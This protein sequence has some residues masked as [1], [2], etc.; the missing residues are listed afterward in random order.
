MGERTSYP[1]GTFCWVDL[2]TDD[3]QAAKAFYGE[4]LGWQYEDTPIGEGQVYSMAR[5]D[6]HDVAAVGPLQGPEGVPPHWNCYVSVEDADATAARAAG[7]GAT[8]LAEPFDVFESGRMA[9]VQDPQGAIVSLWQPNNH[10]GATLVNAI[11]ALTWNDLISPDVDASASFYRGLFGWQI[12]EV[13]ESG[14][15]YWSIL[16]AGN[17]NGG[18]MPQPPD[19]HPAWN[20]YFAVEDVDATLARAAE[21]GGQTIAGPMDIPN[22]TRLAVLADP[23]GAVFSVASGPLDP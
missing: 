19:S 14:G 8:V 11:G 4:L 13:P 2:A 12:D 17:R 6:G 21:R 9:V 16:N 18:L 3:Q 23:Q 10:I 1:P 20:L 22:G 15:Q 7:L 5:L